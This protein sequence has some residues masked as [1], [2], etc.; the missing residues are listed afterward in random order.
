MLRFLFGVALVAAVLG[1]VLA[2]VSVPLSLERVN[3]KGF[4]PRMLPACVTEDSTATPCFWDGKTRGN[5]QG[6]SFWVDDRQ[7][8]H[9]ID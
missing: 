5:G 4:N 9:F 7:R 3:R 8:V 2:V 1:T 6:R